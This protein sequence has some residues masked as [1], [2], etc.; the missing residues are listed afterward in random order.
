MRF[1]ARR[2]CR[3]ATAV[4]FVALL[5]PSAPVRAQAAQNSATGAVA[6]SSP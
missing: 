1:R 4:V 6:G 2:V 5:I 3:F